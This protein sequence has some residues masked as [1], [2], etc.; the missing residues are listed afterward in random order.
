MCY[1]YNESKKK[2]K[3]SHGDL[4]SRFMNKSI[5]AESSQTDTILQ[6]PSD[7][8]T[9]TTN[10]KCDESTFIPLTPALTCGPTNPPSGQQVIPTRPS[11]SDHAAE[12]TSIP[13]NPALSST[14]GPPSLATPP[15]HSP[16]LIPL[17]TTLCMSLF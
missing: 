10:D 4:S 11:A 1:T 3:Q 5:P 14:P 13:I 6:C 2:N 12:S 9:S 16:S 17:N 8:T 15:L 7:T